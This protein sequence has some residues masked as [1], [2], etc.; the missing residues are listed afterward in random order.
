[1]PIYEY[2]CKDCHGSFD[3]IL[4]LAAHDREPITC[5]KCGS[6]NV[7]QG[8]TNFYPITSKKSA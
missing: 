2:L 1:M 8:F 3:K 7:E 6:K 5:P 4:T